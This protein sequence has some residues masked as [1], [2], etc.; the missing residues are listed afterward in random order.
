MV[1]NLRGK[2]MEHKYVDMF[3]QSIEK[4]DRATVSKNGNM[5]VVTFDESWRNVMPQMVVPNLDKLE[6]ALRQYLL[7]TKTV[8]IKSVKYDEKHDESYFLHSLLKNIGND[9]FENVVEMVRRNTNFLLDTSFS[10]LDKKLDLGLIDEENHLLVERVQEYY[11]FETPYMLKFSIANKH[12]TYELPLI[13]YGVE[14]KNGKKVAYVYA[15]QRKKVYKNGF[16]QIEKFEKQ[17]RK[18]N[19]SVK[20]NRDLTPSMVL[21]M[22]AFCGLAK[23]EGIDEIKML[24][25]MNRRYFH[26][27]NVTTEEEQDTVQTMTTDKF[28]KLGLRACDQFEGIDIWSYPNDVDCYLTLKL[29]SAISSKNQMADSV[30]KVCAGQKEKGLG[31]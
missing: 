16:D 12:M 6:V 23:R 31:K 24:D 5:A 15:V 14:E 10:W 20:V 18:I 25:F 27:K 11:G 28:L 22:T 1:V 29:G 8:D 30:F 19:S 7:V 13:R 4:Y 17:I 3:L 9:D 2:I 21:V 26:F